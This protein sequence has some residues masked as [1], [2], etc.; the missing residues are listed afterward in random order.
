MT[1]KPVTIQVHQV[2]LGDVWRGAAGPG[3]QGPETVTGV[4]FNKFNPAKMDITLSNFTV[5]TERTV[6]INKNQWFAV[7]REVP[8]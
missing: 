5:H 7:L 1:Q 8:A 4:V 6:T 3:N 2:L